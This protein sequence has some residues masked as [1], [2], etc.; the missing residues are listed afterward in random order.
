MFLLL[1]YHGFVMITVPDFLHE[2]EAMYG[3]VPDRCFGQIW[4]H[5]V[6]AGGGLKNN[7][8]LVRVLGVPPALLKPLS[9]V[10]PLTSSILM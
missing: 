4:F 7:A 6:G 5:L 9:T 2:F 1:H 10:K 8:Y 3:H